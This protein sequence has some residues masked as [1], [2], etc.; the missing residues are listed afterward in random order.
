MVVREKDIA[1]DRALDFSIFSFLRSPRGS[2]PFHW[3]PC[4][5]I[6]SRRLADWQTSSPFL[7]A[8]WS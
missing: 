5:F 1:L 4:I 6:S 7:Y 2:V 3:S 8:V